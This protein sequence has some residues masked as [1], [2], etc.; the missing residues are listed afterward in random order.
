M[1]TIKWRE[2]L[3][4]DIDVALDLV[5]FRF[6]WEDWLAEIGA[7]SLASA[8]VTGDAGLVI[9]GNTVVGSYVEVIISCDTGTP[10]I[11]GS[12]L[13]ATCQAITTNGQKKAR[14]IIFNV[15]DKQ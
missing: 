13:K 3:E 9:A 1:A 4:Y 14:S 10:P 5:K 8:P 6:E 15:V 7:D 12:Q 11:V 2:D